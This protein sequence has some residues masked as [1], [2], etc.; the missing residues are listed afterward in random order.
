MHCVINYC[1][2][3]Y[4]NW[5]YEHHIFFVITINMS[6]TGN[7]FPL[8]VLMSYSHD[9][10]FGRIIC[11]CG[12]H[13]HNLYAL[14][15]R[16]KC[17]VYTLPCGGSIFGSPAIDEVRFFFQVYT[18]PLIS[19]VWW[20]L[21]SRIYWILSNSSMYFLYSN[22]IFLFLFLFLDFLPC[23]ASVFYFFVNHP[24]GFWHVCLISR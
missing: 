10:I 18:E 16:N 7:S 22:I 19:F 11:R 17:C 8:Q 12:S 23:I 13:D 9:L 6:I 24:V 3:N 14:D 2:D 20:E 5:Q 1:I 21:F 15:Y 4:Y